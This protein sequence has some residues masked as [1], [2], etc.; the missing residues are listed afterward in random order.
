MY[1]TDW[2]HSLNKPFLAPPDFIFAPVWT[3]LY[4]TIAVSFI[5]YVK[6]GITKEKIIP[7]IFFFIQLI[8]NFCWS[9]VFFGMKQI[10]LALFILILMWIFLFITVILFLLRS[11]KAAILLIPY[12]IWTSFAFYLNLGYYILN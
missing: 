4:I 2:F 9:P 6:D 1:N 12:L 10:G 3:I 8:L 11:I 7:L 5:L